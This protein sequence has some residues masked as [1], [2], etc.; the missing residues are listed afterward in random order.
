MD[1]SYGNL[2]YAEREDIPQLNEASTSNERDN[3]P[4]RS[5]YCVVKR[6]MDVVLSVLIL[7]MAVPGFLV[8][9][10]LI[11][12]EDQGPAFYSAKRV[13]RNGQTI[14]VL[15]FR[16]MK[17]NADHLEDMLTP[18]ELE[19]Y[20]KEYKLEHDPR[21][22]KIGKFLRRYSLDELPQLV[23]VL[24]GDMS[25]V[26]PRPLIQ[27]EVESKY[28]PAHRR[29]LL[30]VRPGMT[31]LWQVNG[32]SDCTYESGERQKLELS[33]VKNFSCK[34]DVEILL[35]TVGVVLSKVGAR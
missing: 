32:R 31:G 22:T 21:I 4:R 1:Y 24:K 25:L 29:Q 19:L 6:T 13:G 11:N 12:K 23:N 2:A 16:S 9:M 7:V 35:R 5:I 20:R 17:M 30:S 33:Y 28:S 8:I 26:G 14:R 3:H 27:E 18:E 10:L 15:K 34:M